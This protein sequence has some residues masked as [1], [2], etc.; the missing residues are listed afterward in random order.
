MR[1]NSCFAKAGALSAVVVP[2]GRRSAAGV[3]WRVPFWLRGNR[4]ARRSRAG[5][6]SDGFYGYNVTAFTVDLLPHLFPFGAVYEGFGNENEFFDDL[7]FACLGAPCKDG[8]S[9]CGAVGKAKSYRFMPFYAL[10]LGDL[11][12]H[13]VGR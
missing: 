5:K 12:L 8:Q 10:F 3:P 7:R 1:K 2:R 9:V 13:D 11:P 6:Y 4:R